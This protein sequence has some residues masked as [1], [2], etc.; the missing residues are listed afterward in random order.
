[1]SLP[2]GNVGIM[3]NE[4]DPPLESKPPADT[5]AEA[6]AVMREVFREMEVECQEEDGVL[7]MRFLLE[8]VEVQLLCH[9]SPDDVVS[10]VVKLPLRAREAF[11]AQA[12]EFLHRLNFGEK[13]K[14]WEIDYDDGEI[15][16]AG[17]IDTL[18]GPLNGQLLQAFVHA[19][20]TRADLAFPYLT[21]V[22]SG[23]MTPEF[24]SDQAEAAWMAHWREDDNEDQK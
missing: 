6:L 19:M 5:A 20:L 17:Y 1:M 24:A 14:F 7:F 21:S 4:P 11:R 10:V 8:N 22:I 9:G 18:L 15:R 16:L 3:N 2:P 23:R 12:G 13:R